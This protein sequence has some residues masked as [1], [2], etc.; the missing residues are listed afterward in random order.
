M[1]Y[2]TTQE[3]ITAIY[4]FVSK[5]HVRINA[6]RTICQCP[7]KKAMLNGKAKAYLECIC[8][9]RDKYGKYLLTTD[10]KQV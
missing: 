8:F 5:Q 2:K 1:K 4:S 10:S 7:I 9:I 3:K 6:D